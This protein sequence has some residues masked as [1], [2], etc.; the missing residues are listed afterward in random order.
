MIGG[1]QDSLKV[2]VKGIFA[3]LAESMRILYRNKAGFAGF[4]IVVGYIVM[5]IV[6]PLVVPK[7]MKDPTKIYAPPSFEHPLGTDFQGKDV[8]SQIVH[9]AG[10]VLSTAFLAGLITTMLAVILGLSAG[11][12]G[13]VVD[14]LIMGAADI[15]LTIPQFPLLAVL[16]GIIRLK[17][18]VGLAVIIAVLSWAATAR[19]IRSQV[20]S[21]KERDFIQSARALDLGTRHILFSEI[22]PNI[23]PFIAISFI[24]SIT[25]AIYAQIGLVY[26]GFVPFEESNWGVMLNRAWTFGAIF[27]RNSIF[28]IMGPVIAIAIFQTALIMLNKSLDEL[29]DPRLRRGI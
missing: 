10:L 25:S 15:V 17:D 29:F 24:F 14:S 21:V 8:L 11:F 27:N 6:G 4:I 1:V 5:A 12:R 18:Y 13:G 2:Y 19:A 23:M 26:L 20:L 7:P 22:L 3:G 9:G 28:F 16:A